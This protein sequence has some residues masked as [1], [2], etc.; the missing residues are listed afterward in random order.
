MVKER[1][2]GGGADR[3]AKQVSSG[4]RWKLTLCRMAREVNYKVIEDTRDTYAIYIRV[5]IRIIS[6]EDAKGSI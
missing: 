5:Y 6:Y 1:G 4:E 3:Y 2:R